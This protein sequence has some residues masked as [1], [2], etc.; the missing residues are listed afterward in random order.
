MVLLVH[1]LLTK[2]I[3]KNGLWITFLLSC[4]VIGRGVEEGILDYI[5]DDA[6]KNN[7][8]RLIGNFIPTKKNK[9]SES[10]LANFG[11]KKEKQSLDIFIRKLLQ[12]AIT[13]VSTE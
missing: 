2:I 7:V 4:R 6:K 1:S 8:K 3:Q 10:F 12:E 5:I 11:F 13:F 9:P